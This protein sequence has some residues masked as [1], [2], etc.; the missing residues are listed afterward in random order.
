MNTQPTVSIIVVSWDGWEDTRACL[1]SI[2]R[3]N[4]EPSFEVTL[5]DNGSTDGTPEKAQKLMPS[6]RVERLRENRG[7]AAAANVGLGSSRGEYFLLLNNDVALSP[8]VLRWLVAASRKLDDRVILGPKLVSGDS[9]RVVF[10]GEHIHLGLG[11]RHP[12]PWNVDQ[13]KESD[14]VTGAAMFIPR[15]VRETVGGFDEDF[16]FYFEDVDYCF[17]AGRLGFASRYE[18]SVTLTHAVGRSAARLPEEERLRRYYTGFVQFLRK[19]ASLPAR[20]SSLSLLWIVSQWRRLRGQIA[21]SVALE[22]LRMVRRSRNK[23]LPEDPIVRRWRRLS[24][25]PILLGL[26][27]SLWMAW[28]KS[29]TFD[30]WNHLPAGLAELKTGSVRIAAE[31]PPLLKIWNALPLLAL[32]LSLPLDLPG[33]RDSTELASGTKHT[34]VDTF[35]SENVDQL[36]VITFLGRLPTIVLSLLLALVLGH[37]T[38]KRWGEPAGFI[39]VVIASLEPNLRAHG[40][41]G[42][43]DVGVTLLIILSVWTMLNFLRRPAFPELLTLGVVLGLAQLTRM[44]AL[45][46]FPLLILFCLLVRR[47]EGTSRRLTRKI[48]AVIAIAVLILN[49]G[50]LFQGSFRSLGGLLASLPRY[51]GYAKVPERTRNLLESLSRSSLLT[52]LPVPLPEPYVLG[53]GMTAERARQGQTIYLAGKLRPTGTPL[54]YPLLL[55]TKLPVVLLL[56]I[57]AGILLTLRRGRWEDRMLLIAAFALFLIHDLGRLQLGLRY[58]LPTVALLIPAAAAVAAYAFARPKLRLAMAVLGAWFLAV[59]LL[60]SPNQLTYFN[61]FVGGPRGGSRIAA[62]SNL[63]W[64][65]DLWGLKAELRERRLKAI[66]TAFYSPM[67]PSL[68]GLSTTPFPCER[69]EGIMAISVSE[70][71]GLGRLHPGCADW[72]KGVRLL[73]VIGNTIELYEIQ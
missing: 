29:L 26:L 73:T 54:T 9:A 69:T 12:L 51:E 20:M 11:L 37:I 17:R 34:F 72:L 6:L 42:T 2:A 50:Y 49:F 32:D 4:P 52:S 41:L 28:T 64:G 33:Y 25:I 8:D 57:V 10:S 14:W 35:W 15:R 46:L 68:L 63:D 44:N 58:L 22:A 67:N 23:P 45:I 19:H 38:R 21:G 66:P 16:P 24:V 59:S 65:Q 62:D 47:G 60:I 56:S 27:L 5:V 13:P 39:A 53:L 70:R 30:E 7:Y 61:E 18:P 48:L 55:A 40:S 31:N 71:V 36:R 1:E 3:L 43:L